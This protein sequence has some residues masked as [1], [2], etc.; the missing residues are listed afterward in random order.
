[1]VAMSHFYTKPATHN[2]YFLGTRN[3][4]VKIMGERRDVPLPQRGWDPIVILVKSQHPGNLGAVCRAMMNYGFTKLRLIEP[5]C[6]ITCDEARNRA[7]HAGSILDEAGIF[8]TWEE[9]VADCN[10]VIGTSGKREHGP[11]TVFRHFLNPWDVAELGPENGGKIAIVFGEEGMGLSTPELTKCDL[12]MTLPTWEGY[13]IANLSHAVNTTLYEIHRHHILV[14]G[15]SLGVADHLQLDRTISPEIR[16]LLRQAIRE[17]GYS[18]TGDDKRKETYSTL[19]TRVIMRG[20]PLD[21]EAHR[22]LGAFVEA[23]TAMQ[24]QAGDVDWQKKRRK[25]LNVTEE[26]SINIPF[27]IYEE[28]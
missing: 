5:Q 13:P 8:S 18:L 17:F 28:E 24:K 23:T 12:L 14:Q 22:L 27:Q 15:S 11:K 7:K 16:K 3:L 10:L 6:D 2:G 1:M 4:L 21:I 25:R 19:L 9:A 20:M 26:S